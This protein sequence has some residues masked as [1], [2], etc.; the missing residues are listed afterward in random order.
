MLI[1]ML[2]MTML[3]IML[4]MTILIIMLIIILLIRMLII[5]M[6]II[7]IGGWLHPLDD[8]WTTREVTA[9]WQVLLTY[10]YLESQ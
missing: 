7:I 4:I 6:L 9:Y 5:I 8:M 10:V 1:I 2:I 3:I